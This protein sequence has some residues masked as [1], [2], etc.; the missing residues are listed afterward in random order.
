MKHT[1]ADLNGKTYLITGA[2]SGMGAAT[3]RTLGEV[4][5]NVVLAARRE[6][7]CEAV[8]QDVIR[9]GGRA[10]VLR[11]DV[12]VERDLEQAVKATVEHFGRLDGAFNNAGV[13]GQTKPL[14]E[15]SSSEFEAVMRTNVMGVFGAM[16]YQIAAMLPSGGG[17]IVNNASIV[18][19]VGFPNMAHYNASKHAVMGLTRTAA[20][21]YFQRGIRINAVCPGPVETPMA[22]QGFGG[23]DA[24]Q[25]MMKQTP[26]GR[27]GQPAEVALPV[28]FLLSQAASYIS[29]QGL[30]VDGGFTV[31]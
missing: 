21:E 13:L 4:G 28:L 25:A 23:V 27:A 16:K 11:V 17:A 26:A 7:A 2:S 19:Q 29:G 15:M 30:T 3:A 14:H 20:L 1:L 12:D 22:L 24:L 9:A 5:A 18:A 10:L 8:A 31:Q 6:Q